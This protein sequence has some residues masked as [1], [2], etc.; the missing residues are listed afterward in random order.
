M[1]HPLYTEGNR[2]IFLETAYETVYHLLGERSF[3]MDI[4]HV[5]VDNPSCA[6]P[7][8]IYSLEE[9]GA[10]VGRRNSSMVVDHHGTLMSLH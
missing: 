1:Y 5:E 8:A 6:D 2:R 4:N 3:G 9:L 7:S 10:H